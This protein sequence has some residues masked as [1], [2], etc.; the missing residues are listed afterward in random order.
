MS[1]FELTEEA[2]RDLHEI[3]D[4]ISHDSLDAADRILEEFY[5]AFTSLA[6]MPGKGHTRKDLTKQAVLFW[7]VRSYLV[8]Y[9]RDSDPLQIIAVLHGKRNVKKLLK[10]R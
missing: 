1:R 7:L 3:W 5:Q 6:A 10:G 8:I 4:Y 2:L 9:K